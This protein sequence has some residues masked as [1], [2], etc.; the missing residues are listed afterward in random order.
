MISPIDL[1]RVLRR[2][3]PAPAPRPPQPEPSL[4]N[5]TAGRRAS[6][7]GMAEPPACLAPIPRETDAATGP[8]GPLPDVDACGACDAPR[9][10]HGTRYATGVGWHEWIGPGSD[11]E[12]QRRRAHLIAGGDAA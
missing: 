1:G 9:E 4:P 7:D 8:A 2:R 3:G 6:L 5:R 11:Q 10:G 12:E